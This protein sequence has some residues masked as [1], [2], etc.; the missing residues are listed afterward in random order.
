MTINSWRS[1]DVNCK[2]RQFEGLPFSKVFIVQ[3][4][5]SKHS[6]EQT[7]ISM[8][9]RGSYTEQCGPTVW[10]CE[11]GQTILHIAGECHSDRFHRSGGQVLNLNSFLPL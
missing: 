10:D 7:Y 4:T 2:R 6:H 3:S 1:R 9:L 8:V 5:H 11:T